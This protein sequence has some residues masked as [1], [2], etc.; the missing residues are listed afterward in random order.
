MR[1]SASDRGKRG[2]VRVIYFYGGERVP[3]TRFS[4]MRRPPGPT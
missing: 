1:F 3:S 2:G 4:P